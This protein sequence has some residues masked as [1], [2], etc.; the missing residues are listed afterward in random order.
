ML[1]YRLINKEK[2]HLISIPERLLNIIETEIKEDLKLKEI[3]EKIRQEKANQ[4]TIRV[5]HLNNEKTFIFSKNDIFLNLIE[6][7]ETEFSLPNNRINWRIRA[8]SLFE[9]LMTDSYT[10]K[11]NFTLEELKIKNFKSF[12]I[13]Y[14]FDNEVFIEYDPN[15]IE[16]KICLWKEGI[17]SLEEKEL[18]P[19]KILISQN[20]ILEELII[21]IEEN[22]GIPKENICLIRRNQ[23]IS[24]GFS[25]KINK[26][27]EDLK[28]DLHKLKIFNGLMIYVEEI[29]GLWDKVKI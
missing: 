16:L 15:K 14:K 24:K 7:V 21:K 22:T 19:F 23:I 1:F 12:I 13:E 9:D 6:Q 11:E 8:Y 28:K 27:I 2:N 17:N 3:E 29:Q 10:N 25:E 20:A 5:F 26:N 18:K 4:L